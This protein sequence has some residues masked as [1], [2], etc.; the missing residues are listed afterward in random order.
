MFEKLNSSCFSSS[1]IGLPVKETY[2]NV[3]R[4]CVKSGITGIKIQN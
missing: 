4:I 2:V 3:L 1:E